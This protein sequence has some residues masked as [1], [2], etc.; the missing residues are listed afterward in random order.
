MLIFVL[1]IV[2]TELGKELYL[3][4]LSGGGRKGPRRKRIRAARV[5]EI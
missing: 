1:S 4:L 2:E 3:R 5:R